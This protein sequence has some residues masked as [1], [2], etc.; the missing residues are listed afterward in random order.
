M[1]SRRTLLSA[2]AALPAFSDEPWIPL[3]DGH[4]ITNWR[5]AEHPNS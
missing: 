2:L 1:I 3:F 4:S 5:P